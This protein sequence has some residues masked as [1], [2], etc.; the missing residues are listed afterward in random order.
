MNQKLFTVPAKRIYTLLPGLLSAVALALFSIWLS[1][2]VGVRV[3]DMEKS[4]LS[5][6]MIAIL[7]GLIISNLVRIPRS[8]MPGL[9]FAVK[10]VLRLGII[11]LGIR[12]SVVEI[13]RLGSVG[14]PI[15]AGC[16]IGALFFT[17]ALSRLLGV[18]ER[19]GVLI[20]VG[21]SICG[22]S[23]ILA[24]G[25]AIDSKEE[26]VAYAVSIIT[27]FGI[28]ATLIYPYL[29]HA[30]FNGEAIR[31]G[32]FLGTAIHDTSQVTGAGLVYTQ[33]F[34]EPSAL[35]SAVVTKLV[36]N[37]F[38]AVVIPL[39]AFL[40]NRRKESGK[41]G[42]KPSHAGFFSLF[43]YFILGFVLLGVVRS[44]GDWTLETSSSAFGFFGE[45]QWVT[46]YNFIKQAAV[47]L[48]V[49]AL[50]GLGLKTRFKELK[51]LGI[52]PFLVGFASAVIVGVISV[53]LVTLL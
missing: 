32:I 13:V 5:A 19:L 22:V 41:R 53:L 9:T 21:T 40:H 48:L 28:A 35:N 11:L 12:L 27:V 36:R 37:I 2:F 10:I 26:E 16:I 3:L 6:V 44:V 34:H 17:V 47:L 29:A 31:V 20:A 43:P 23:A 14:V 18:P 38:M 46:C 33:V 15:V 24:A 30:I 25:P 1:N 50:A 52:K 39:M 42:E 4:P 51:Q 49:V 45:D 7:L 8:L